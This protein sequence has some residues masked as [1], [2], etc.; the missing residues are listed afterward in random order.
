MGGDIRRLFEI[1]LTVIY[2]DKD[3]IG[4]LMISLPGVGASNIDSISQFREVRA[5]TIYHEE[6]EYEQK[7]FSHG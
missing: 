7:M 6:G 1:E 3:I 4:M 5:E 2:I